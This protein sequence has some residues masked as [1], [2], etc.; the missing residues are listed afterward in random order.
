MSRLELN[1]SEGKINK[2]EK[3][4]VY[5]AFDIEAGGSGYN[6][7]VIA[8]GVCYGTA[9]QYQKKRW[10]IQFDIKDFE[11]RCYKEFWSYNMDLLDKLKK[12][13]VDK[14]IAWREIRE[15]IDNLE[16]LFPADKYRV[17]FVSDNPAYDI[18]RIDFMLFLF[19]QRLP[20]RY[21]KEGKYRRISDPSEQMKHFYDVNVIHNFVSNRGA[22]A[23]HFPDDDAEVMMLQQLFLDCYIKIQNK[24]NQ[25]VHKLKPSLI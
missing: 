21:T 13:A 7:P 18:S 8:V 10:V 12:E 16:I 4:N 17:I 20:L 5:V 9:N 6:H 1:S 22:K 15:F 2:H 3:E 23:T 14:K 25:L 11:E 24:N 19:E